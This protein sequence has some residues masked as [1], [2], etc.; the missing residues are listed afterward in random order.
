MKTRSSSI[1]GWIVVYGD[2]IRVDRESVVAD[3][4]SIRVVEGVLDN[5]SL[6]LSMDSVSGWRAL[7]VYVK[8]ERGSF[9]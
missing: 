6:T 4:D 2:S 3:G 5:T 8:R 7:V 1:K 9:G